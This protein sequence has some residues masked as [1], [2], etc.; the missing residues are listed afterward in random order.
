MIDATT[1]KLKEFVSCDTY[2]TM[3]FSYNGV[4]TTL[5]DY[6]ASLKDSIVVIA[7]S[8]ADA[9]DQNIRNVLNC[10]GGFPDFGTWNSGQIGHVFIGM[11]KR[12]DGTYPLQPRQGYEE[13]NNEDGSTPEI[14]CTLSKGRIVTNGATGP[15]GNKGDSGKDGIA[16]KDGVGIKTTTITYAISTDGTTAPTTGWTSSVPAVPAGQFL[17]TRTIWSYTDG[18]NET[19]YSVAKAGDMGKSVWSY[20]YDRGD[21]RLGNWWVS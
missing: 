12:S 18:T 10:M 2:I 16:G 19:G 4:S 1:H 14:G 5:A 15:K 11:S 3:S 20:P 17:W 13:V 21:N 8:D 7:A 6:L 9:V